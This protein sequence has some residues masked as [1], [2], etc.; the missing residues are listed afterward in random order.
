MLALMAI[1]SL[2]LLAQ[3]GKCGDD[4]VYSFD[5]NTLKIQNV[6]KKGLPAAIENYDMSRNLAP[7]RKKKLVPASRASVPAPLPTVTICRRSF[8]KA[9]TCRR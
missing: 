1:L 2:P 7:W 9:P 3:E 4:V 8:S 5:G 6:N